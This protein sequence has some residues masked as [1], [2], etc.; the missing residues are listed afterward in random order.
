[1]DKITIII[2][3][4][5]EEKRI[6]T[7]LE[8]YGSFFQKMRIERKIDAKILVVIN[9]TTDETEKIVKKYSKKYPSIKYIDLVLG[10]KGYAVTEGFKIALEE[11]ADYVGFSDADSATSPEEFM[12]LIVA[13]KKY[14]GAIA[15]RYLPESVIKPKPSIQRLIARRMFNFVIR[16]LMFLPYGDTQCGAKVFKRRAINK[17]ISELTMSQWAFDVEMLYLLKKRG[18]KIVS[19]PIKWVDKEYSTINFWQAGPWMVLGIL[20][21]RIL[22]SPFRVF[23]KIYDKLIGF[24]PK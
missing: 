23:M 2:P 9:N 15:D 20:R 6:G 16:A 10:G 18:F 14:D 13:C 24:V 17:I 1:M 5:N 3:A 11:K 4:Y 21:L 8:E 7:T 19:I 22:N 12:K